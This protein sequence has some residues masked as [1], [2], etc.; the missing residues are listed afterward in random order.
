MTVEL[1]NQLVTLPLPKLPFGVMANATDRLARL[2]VLRQPIANMLDIVEDEATYFRAWRTQASS[3]EALHR[4]Y[5]TMELSRQFGFAKVAV[6][7]RL[8]RI[9]KVSHGPRQISGVRISIH[10]NACAQYIRC[11][12][13]LLVTQCRPAVSARGNIDLVRRPNSK[14]FVVHSGQLSGLSGTKMALTYSIVARSIAATR[15]RKGSQI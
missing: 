1:S 13:R 15:A 11:N 8:G 10:S 14:G 2:L 6:K 3:S 9:G 5:R 7:N 12:S 4:A